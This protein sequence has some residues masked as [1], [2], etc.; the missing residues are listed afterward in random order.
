[1]HYEQRIKKA[2]ESNQIERILLID[3]AYDPPTFDEEFVA[4]LAESLAEEE[5][6]EIWETCGI[7][8]SIIASAR[9]AA[10]EGDVEHRELN[11]VYNSLFEKFVE[12][13]DACFDLN[14]R[15]DVLKGSALAALRPLEA[16]LRSCGGTI[17]T[18]GLFDAMQRFQEFR[19]QVLFL[20]YYLSDEV[21]AERNVSSHKMSSARQASLDLLQQL[22]GK[23]KPAEIPAI[24]LMS[25]R[26]KP[27]VKRFRHQ[28][29][30]NQILSL[31]FQFLH[32]NLLAIEG[33]EITIGNDAADALLD[34]S[35]GFLFGKQVQQALKLWKKGA[36]DALADFL[37]EVANLEIKD[38]AYLL[39]FRLR[40]EGQPFGEYLEWFL[41]ECLKGLIEETV[42]WS[43]SSFMELDNMSKEEQ[44]IGIEGA[45]DGPTDTVAHLYHR[46]R[47]GGHT[48]NGKRDYRLGDLYARTKERDIR[49]II[50][51]D[52]DL[53][54]GRGEPKAKV[55]L[56]VVGEKSSFDTKESSA[57][58][59]LMHEDRPNSVC[60]D[61]KNLETFAIKGPESLQ[62][63]KEFEYIGTLR[64]LYAQELQRRVLT[65]LSRLGLPVSPAL[66]I[67][68]PLKVWVRLVNNEMREIEFASKC[69]GTIIPQRRSGESP[70][71]LL[72]RKF[73]G[74][75][76]EKLAR[77]D[78]ETVA[79]ADRKHLAKLS[80][81]E[82]YNALQ[83]EC[84]R[85]GVLVGK[86]IKKICSFAFGDQPNLAND[87]AWLQIGIKV[88][89][90]AAESIQTMDPVVDSSGQASI[91]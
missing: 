15:F 50:T 20:D 28:L 24:V 78:M 85:N 59:F 46:V 18:V 30:N 89:E 90:R 17:Q 14:D 48:G 86:K 63:K 64:P 47:V 67:N 58:D 25:T 3:D 16:L 81:V 77:I 35:Q 10:E 11:Q 9:L 87:A 82:I 75:M 22:V 5:C 72:R 60:W 21:P 84:L 54:T 83:E 61:T 55:V 70:R 38:F 52:C 74:E 68:V 19:P 26:P 6:K 73:F 33:E 88:S 42:D 29:K 53:V 23:D 80:R 43:H 31:R 2:F 44:S 56:T 69:I 62:G 65:D 71:V 1:M 37:E 13:N 45:H 4:A 39:R 66:G 36:D 12:T 76:M 41:G 27:Q 40:E 57:D 49:A 34:M 8:Q 91:N 51:P 32:K 7:E 79:E